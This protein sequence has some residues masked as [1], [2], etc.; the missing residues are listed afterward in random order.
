MNG[1]GHARA[2]STGDPR[3]LRQKLIEVL[4]GH[5]RAEPHAGSRSYLDRLCA[6]LQSADM[7]MPRFPEVARELDRLLADDEPNERELLRTVSEEPG[8]V[9]EIWRVA[10]TAPYTAAPRRLDQ[11]MTRVGIDRL[12]QLGVK[13]AMAAEHF[14]AP[15]FE[16][17]VASCRKAAV[18]GAEISGWLAGE[19]R[20]TVYLGALLRDLGALWALSRVVGDTPRDRPRRAL[21][22]RI[23]ADYHA[24]LTLV[25]LDTWSMGDDVRVAASHHHHAQ[26]A[27]RHQGAAAFVALGELAARAAQAPD[28]G[29]RLAREMLHWLHDPA[30]VRRVIVRAQGLW[31]A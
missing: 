11:A 16:Q 15:G 24:D 18:V 27:P 21:V 1:L 4:E 9:Q 28:E 17:E 19:R 26:A 3:R 8:L 6:G 12:W 29:E 30:Q 23:V 25:A 7:Q 2:P 5:Q 22:E 14:L 31:A 13:Q 10:S 20:G